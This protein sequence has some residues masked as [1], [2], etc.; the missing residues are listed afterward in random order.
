MNNHRKLNEKEETIRISGTLDVVADYLKSKYQWSYQDAA[1]VA[2]LLLVEQECDISEVPNLSRF[3]ENSIE[4]FIDE[5]KAQGMFGNM[6][7][8]FNFTEAKMKVMN[9]IPLYILDWMITP[10]LEDKKLLK[11]FFSILETLASCARIIEDIHVC[12][13]CRAWEQASKNHMRRFDIERLFSE[14]DKGGDK[15]NFICTLA[16]EDGEQRCGHSHWKCKLYMSG[17]VCTLTENKLMGIINKLSEERII[18][19]VVEK[20]QYRFL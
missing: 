19:P 5:Q 1:R 3:S 16:S 17:N 2:L 11:T 15:S 9:A 12:V 18:E 4:S 8:F 10:E 7:V 14:K 6:R 13:C 20:K